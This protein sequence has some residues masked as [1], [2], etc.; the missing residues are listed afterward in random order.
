MPTSNPKSETSNWTGNRG[1]AVQFQVSDFGF[2][3]GFRPISNSYAP[4]S[5]YFTL[6][7]HLSIGPVTVLSAVFGENT[8][9]T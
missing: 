8:S 3:V 2:E 4:Q 9:D 5:R 7:I 1:S 6:F